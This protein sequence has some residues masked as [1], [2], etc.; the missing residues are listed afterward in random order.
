MTTTIFFKERTLL[1]SWLSESFA[2]TIKEEFEVDKVLVSEYKTKA[3]DGV[4]LTGNK[5]VIC[6]EFTPDEAFRLLWFLKNDSGIWCY[7]DDVII[8]ERGITV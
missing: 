2:K 4:E 1:Y 5:I 8:N 7:V 6:K 3:D